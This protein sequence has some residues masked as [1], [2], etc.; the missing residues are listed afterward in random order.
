MPE[1]ADALSMADWEE[2][3]VAGVDDVAP[4]SMLGVE[5]NG[6]PFVI[7]NLE[8]HF[9]AYRDQCPHQGARMSCG[10]ITGAMLPASRTEDYTYGLEGQVISCPRH[11]WK[12]LI[13][14]G[15]SLFET[16][17][18]RLIPVPLR[19]QDG[20]IFLGVQR[21]PLTGLDVSAGS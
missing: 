18:R 14:T 3:D 21:K 13:A 20:R 19:V 16:D 17:R 7:F 11:H 4:G 10:V 9:H 1:L 12:F 2:A 8:G 15:E 5:A 6:R